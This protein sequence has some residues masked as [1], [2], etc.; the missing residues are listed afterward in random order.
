MQPGPCVCPVPVGGGSR[1]PQ[2]L[3]RLV[4]GEPGEDAELDEL[5][6]LGLMHGQAAQRLVEVQQVILG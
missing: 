5:R 1:E 3:T 2:D 4:D 6:G